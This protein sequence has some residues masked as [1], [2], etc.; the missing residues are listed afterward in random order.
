MY[1]G[2][3]WLTSLL[4][5]AG[6]SRRYANTGITAFNLGGVVG[7]LAGRRAPSRAFGSRAAML[8][9]GRRGGGERRWCLSAM[10]ISP[11]IGVAPIIAMLTLTGAHDQRRADDDVRAGGARLSQ[12]VRATGVGTA[13]SFGRIGAVLTGYVGSWAIEYGG[14]DVVLRR[15]RRARWSSAFVALALVRRHV[16]AR[17]HSSSRLKPAVAPHMRRLKPCRHDYA[18]TARAV[19]ATSSSFLRCSSGDRRLPSCVEANPHC[20]LSASRSSGTI[21]D[22]SAMR[23]LQFLGRLQRRRASS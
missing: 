15:D 22:A 2:F 20:G 9:D 7:A 10:T 4:T 12:P 19:V 13:V 16:P 8:D 23:R 5:G 17:T 6:F 18:H 21:R 1:L 14:T 3:S 11:A